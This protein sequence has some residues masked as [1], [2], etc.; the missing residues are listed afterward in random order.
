MLRGLRESPNAGERRGRQS[1]THPQRR[2]PEL[3]RDRVRLGFLR[4][5]AFRPQLSESVW[6]ATQRVSQACQSGRIWVVDPEEGELHQ[7]ARARNV[8]LRPNQDLHL[9]LPGERVDPA[10]LKAKKFPALAVGTAPTAHTA[11]SSER[12]PSRPYRLRAKN[13][14]SLLCSNDAMGG[15]LSP[16]GMQ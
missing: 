10:G 9:L 1:P 14:H 13:G 15:K 7:V 8:L 4:H 2:T 3:K 5:D 16:C 11:H 12:E 6:D